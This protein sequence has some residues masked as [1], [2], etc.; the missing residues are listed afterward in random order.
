[1]DIKE[2]KYW[3]HPSQA[4]CVFIDKPELSLISIDIWC[5]AGV[6]F[7]SK[8][9]EGIAHLLEHMIFKGNKK[10]NTTEFDLKIESLGGQSNASTSYDDVHYFV[11]IPPN[12]FN[13][14]LILLANLVLLPDFNSSDYEL[15]KK[16]VIDEILQSHDQTDERIYNYFINRVWKG[17]RYGKS[18]LGKEEEIN[19]ITISDLKK[20]HSKQY[21]PNNICLAI[22]GKLPKDYLEILR[23]LKINFRNPV[24]NSKKV[25][26]QQFFIR[27]CREVIMY[28]KLE[29]SRIYIGW[30]IPKTS[31]QKTLLGFEI[32]S[33][34]LT[35]GRNSIL[36]RIL[37]EDYQLVESVFS[38]INSGEFGSL[39]IVEASCISKNID[40][41][42]NIINKQIEKIINNHF[43]F[44]EVIQK[45]IRILKSNYIFNLE[46]SS[47]LASFYGNHLLW[48][49]RNMLIELEKNF[50]Y[51]EN[52][53][54]FKKILKF[55]SEEKFTL[56]AYK[57]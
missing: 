47:Q 23:N 50:K 41:V 34:A 18:I 5:K 55:L 30:Q 11:D 43:E 46:T 38:D 20:F 44:S 26:Y 57:K 36:N 13:E 2:I 40:R 12:N 33:S 4:E 7:E 21:I 24:N 52:L 19:N 22:A 1:M 3:K 10:I 51:W 48:G 15:E 37:R 31:D 32:I 16:V 6:Y 29:F 28:E 49:R 27:K 17:S 56:I 39:F 8:N 53:S 14:A 35:D 42:E 54:N 45:S 25:E 9:K